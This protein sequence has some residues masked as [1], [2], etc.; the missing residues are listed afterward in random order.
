MSSLESA[1][2]KVSITISPIFYSEKNIGEY[3]YWQ[4]GYRLG[5][6]NHLFTRAAAFEY[7]VTRV[8]DRVFYRIKHSSTRQV[9]E[10]AEC[11]KF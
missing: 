11:L 10:V 5:A 1:A 6:V 2:A 4:R 3:R 9:P 7:F 8:L